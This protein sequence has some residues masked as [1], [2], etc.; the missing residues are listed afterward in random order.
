MGLFRYIVQGFGWEIGSQAAREGIAAASTALETEEPR[1]LDVHK[2]PPQ[3][4]RFER[5]ERLREARRKAEREAEIDA[6]LEELKQRTR[7]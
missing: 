4:A 6:L 3:S 2:H 5:I 1:E 7:Q